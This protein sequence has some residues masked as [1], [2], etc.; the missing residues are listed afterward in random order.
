MKELIID[1]AV[2]NTSDVIDFVDDCFS[3]YNCK[4]LTKLHIDTAVEEVFVNISSYAYGT[5]TG[6]VKVRVSVTGEPPA[7][8]I[9]FSDSGKQYD[10]LE[11]NDP[12]ISLPI[13][14]RPIGG[15]GIYVVKHNM[16]DVRY[17]Y[18]DGNNILTIKKILL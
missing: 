4:P 11:K 6:K 17:E 18:T 10:P 12:D 16:D 7:V 8:E 14:Q 15:L 1:A 13:E 5:E 3:T 9:I 2:E